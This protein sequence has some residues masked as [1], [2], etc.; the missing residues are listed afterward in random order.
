MALSYGYRPTTNILNTGHTVHRQ[1]F[2]DAN[3]WQSPNSQIASP[4][5]LSFSLNTRYKY[6]QHTVT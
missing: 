5:K 4:Q 1:Q 6:T 3:Q 2:T